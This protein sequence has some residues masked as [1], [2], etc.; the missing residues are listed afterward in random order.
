MYVVLLCVVMCQGVELCLHVCL[1]FLRGGS[2]FIKSS[3]QNFK[4][5]N[6]CAFLPLSISQEKK[7]KPE[8]GVVSRSPYGKAEEGYLVLDYDCLFGLKIAPRKF[9]GDLYPISL[10]RDL[11]VAEA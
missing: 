8:T 2:D 1:H 5:Q 3:K 7:V 10:S 4:L 6:Q 9:R 11:E